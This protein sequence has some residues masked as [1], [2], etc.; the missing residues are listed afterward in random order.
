MEIRIAAAERDRV[1]R[2][3]LR[4]RT[5]D[6]NPEFRLIRNLVVEGHPLLEGFPLLYDYEWEVEP[7]RSDGGCG[8]LV[9]TDGEGGFAVVEAKYIDNARTGST[10]RAK[11]TDG[12]KAVR[13][14]ALRYAAAF[15]ASDAGTGAL[16]VAFAL[17]NESGLA[18]ADFDPW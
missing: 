10:A 11:R 17:T 9:F 3:Y 5:W 14:Q 12:R 8:D 1:L 18:R 16:V 2:D 4:G 13:E 7:G 6:A 15:R